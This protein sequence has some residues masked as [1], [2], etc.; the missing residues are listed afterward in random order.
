MGPKANEPLLQ[1]TNA[2]RVRPNMPHYGVNVE[3]TGSMLSWDWVER[4][5]ASARNYWLCTTCPDGKPH[6]APVWGA[7]VEGQLFTATDR[8]SVKARNISQ[9]SRVVVHLESGDET[10]IFEGLLR[11]STPPPALQALIDQNYIDKYDLDPNLE[12][13]DAV[14]Y[15]LIPCKVMAW[16]E[17][18]FPLTATYWLFDD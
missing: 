15:R 4:Q 17:R 14:L 6:A 11:E 18:D 12:E 13:E 16:L 9:D 7:W 1:P 3:E 8:N 5:M 2:R 10:V